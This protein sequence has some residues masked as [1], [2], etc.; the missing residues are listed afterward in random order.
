MKLKSGDE[1]ISMDIIPSQ[2]VATLEPLLEAQDSGDEE[3]V[4][5]ETGQGPW[6]LVITTGGYGKRT[7]ISSF[8]LQKRSGMGVRG[9]KFKSPKD[10][11]AAVHMVEPEDELMIVTNRGI[12]V[13]QSVDDISIQSRMATGVRVHRIDQD[14]AIA[15]VALVPPSPEGEDEEHLESED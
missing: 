4:L 5:E 8:R 10:R 12:M 2:I 15:A 11:L 9:I 1:L 7:P 13:R 14:D 6:V 3:E